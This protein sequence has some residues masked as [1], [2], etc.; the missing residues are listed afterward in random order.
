M[1]NID[2]DCAVDDYVLPLWRVTSKS[3]FRQDIRTDDILTHVRKIYGASV[4]VRN[5]QVRR[6][7]KTVATVRKL[8]D[9]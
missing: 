7:R 6:G 3:N 8:T 2:T 1:L 9:G 4:I 5:G